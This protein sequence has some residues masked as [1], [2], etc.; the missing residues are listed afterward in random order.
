MCIRDSAGIV[1]SCPIV[2]YA[3]ADWDRLLAVNLRAAFLV[4]Q[5]AARVM[6]QSHVAGKIIFTSSWVQDVSWPEITPYNVSKSA[7]RTLMR[8]MARELAPHAIRVNAIAPGIV[9]TGMAKRQWDTDP[10]YRRR[11]EKAIPLGTVTVV[12]VHSC[13]DHCVGPVP[14]WLILPAT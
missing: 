11:A 9:G 7:V 2:D 13:P 1:T 12:P 3:E 4:A 14:I 6:I 8:G 5:R 10:S